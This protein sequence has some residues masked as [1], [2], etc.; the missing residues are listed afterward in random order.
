[1]DS[2]SPVSIQVF[3]FISSLAFALCIIRIQVRVNTNKFS[4]SSEYWCRS[5]VGRGWSSA[6][7]KFPSWQ[8][9]NNSNEICEDLHFK[10]LFYWFESEKEGLRSIFSS[11]LACSQNVHVRRTF[12]SVNLWKSVV[13]LVKLFLVLLEFRK[14]NSNASCRAIFIYLRFNFR[15]REFV[16][17]RFLK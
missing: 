1:M 4:R 12:A 6:L 17:L 2:S 15:Q 9:K 13:V 16:Y 11:V 14:R 7:L 10:Y 5:R 8:E 3:C